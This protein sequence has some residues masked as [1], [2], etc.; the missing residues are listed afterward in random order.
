MTAFEE[1]LPLAFRYLKHQVGESPYEANTLES[2]KL[3]IRRKAKDF[4]IKDNC[5]FYTFL[6]TDSAYID[7]HCRCLGAKFLRL[8]VCLSVSAAGIE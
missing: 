6:L 7:V 8:S 5:M 1:L 2:K 3:V 4:T